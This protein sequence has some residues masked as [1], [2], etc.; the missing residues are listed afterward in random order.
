M[1][2]PAPGSLLGPFRVG[3]RLGV[4]GMGVVFT[5]LDTQLN[6]QVALKV[7]TPY[8]ADEP[9]F[10]AR[11]I[12]EAQTQASLDSP[13]VV[14][15]YSFGEA[16]GRLY[17]ASQLIPDGDLGQMLARHGRPPARIAVN[18]ISQV[19]DGLDTAHD[20]G[21]STATSSRP[22]CCCATATTP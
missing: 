16:D 6:R 2:D 9:D 20:A 5:A 14:Q 12:R 18:L 10:R 15:V 22:T 7:I 8:I 1:D 13:H 19:A 4:G 3:E 11:F 21:S 17:I